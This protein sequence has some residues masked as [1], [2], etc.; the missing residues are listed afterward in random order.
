M[1]LT[2]INGNLNIAQAELVSKSVAQTPQ[3][4]TTSPNAGPDTVT[5]SA[6]GQQAAMSAGDVDRDGDSH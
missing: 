2:A 3:P 5:I 6:A 4:T 1:S